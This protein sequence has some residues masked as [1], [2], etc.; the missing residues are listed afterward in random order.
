MSVLISIETMHCQLTW[1]SLYEWSSIRYANPHRM[2]LCRGIL[3]R[4][5]ILH[6]IWS[7]SKY[8][9]HCPDAWIYVKEWLENT[10][11]SE[12]SGKSTLIATVRTD[13]MTSSNPPRTRLLGNNGSYSHMAV[14]VSIAVILVI[15]LITAMFAMLMTCPQHL[16]GIS[17]SKETPRH[18][19]S[20]HIEA[21]SLLHPMDHMIFEYA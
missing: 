12:Q 18:W 16:N 6:C 17:V 4:S 5:G 7:F 14:A 15:W 10:R 2:L 1:H 3:S 8:S 19:R 21:D 20:K 9:I 11:K 13:A